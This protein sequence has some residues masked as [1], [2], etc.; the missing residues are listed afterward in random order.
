MAC[1]R[2]NTRV[3][4]LFELGVMNL[5]PK[6]IQPYFEITQQ[7]GDRD[8][9]IIEGVLTCCNAQDFEVFVVGEIKRRPFSKMHLFSENDRIV[10]EARCRKCGRVIPLFDSGSDGYEKCGNKQYTPMPMKP[11]DCKKCQNGGFSVRIR[12]EYPD[13]QELKELEVP[14]IDTAFTWIWITL[15]CNKCGARYEKFVDCETA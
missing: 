9:S 12:Y 1:C 10:I 8:N 14:E 4:S 5:I 15:V 13:I 2:R 3:G 6:K 7:T 11:V